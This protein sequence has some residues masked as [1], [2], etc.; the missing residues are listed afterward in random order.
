VAKPRQIGDVVVL[1]IPVFMMYGKDSLVG[2][3]ALC[4]LKGQLCP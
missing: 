3:G 1:P 2:A 4:A